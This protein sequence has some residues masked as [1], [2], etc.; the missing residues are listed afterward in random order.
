MRIFQTNLYVHGRIKYT[1]S[2]GRLDGK[3]LA[4]VAI[5]D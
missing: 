1:F 5:V 3:N 4:F 2:H